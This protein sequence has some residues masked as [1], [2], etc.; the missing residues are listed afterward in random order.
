MARL[1]L[2]LAVSILAAACLAPLTAEA[3]S[4][5]PAFPR[6]L[7]GIGTE[8]FWDIGVDGGWFRFTSAGD[9]KPRAARVT[10][11]EASGTLRFAGMLGEWRMRA[12]IRRARCSDGMS[13]RVY[14]YTLTLTL[15]GRTLSGCAYPAG[16]R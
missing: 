13:E 11:R 3:R 9:E 7:A 15:D 6:R 12:V 10:R 2:A 8:P 4:T 16:T 5:A 14:P 1:P